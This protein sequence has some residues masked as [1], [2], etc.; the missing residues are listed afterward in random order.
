VVLALDEP[1][2]LPKTAACA[3]PTMRTAMGAY[4]LR[5]FGQPCI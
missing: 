1:Q 2:A 4:H 3:A 5:P